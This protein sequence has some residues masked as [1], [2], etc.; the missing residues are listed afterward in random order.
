M[1]DESQSK[2]ILRLK[3][4][5]DFSGALRDLELDIQKIIKSLEFTQDEEEH[6]PEKLSPRQRLFRPLDR[7][8]DMGFIGERTARRLQWVGMQAL[9][10]LLNFVQNEVSRRNNI[11]AVNKRHAEVPP[12]PLM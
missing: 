7:V 10:L 2:L 6:N 11:H 12:F 4:A 9:V 1:G 5:W 3:K 8:F